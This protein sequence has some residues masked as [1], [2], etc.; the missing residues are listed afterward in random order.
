M[1]QQDGGIFS[2]RVEARRF[3]KEAVDLCA[4]FGGD[5]EV[6]EFGELEL[7][8]SRGVVEMREGRQLRRRLEPAR[9]ISTGLAAALT[10][11]DDGFAV[12]RELHI[13][14]SGVAGNCD[15]RAAARDRDE[16]DCLQAAVTV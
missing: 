3:Q 12:R 15:A 11:E 6:F 16:L 13:V 8:P 2:Q 1:E 10:R 4:V 14:E 7:A 5:M 9:Q